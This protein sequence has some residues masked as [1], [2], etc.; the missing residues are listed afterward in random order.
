MGNALTDI[1]LLIESDS[2]LQHLNLPKGS[3]QLINNQQLDELRSLLNF[4]G[5]VMAAGGSA[6]N[7]I[8]GIARLGGKAGYFGCVGDDAIGQF[9]QNDLIDTGVTPHLTHSVNPSGTCTVLVSAD[10]E[11]TMCT[12]LGAAGE[13][14]LDAVVPELF[15]GYHYFHIEGYLAQNNA[16]ITKAIQL[17]KE[18]GLTVSIDL[19]SYNVVES[20][21]TF[22]REII[23][24]YVDIIFANEEEAIAFTGMPPGDAL[25]HMDHYCD[26]AIVKI[27]KDGSMIRKNKKTYFVEPF[28]V[29]CKDTTGAG[30]LYAAGFLF[31]LA[32]DFPLDKCGKIASYVSSKVVEVIGAKMED[33]QWNEI[34][35]KLLTF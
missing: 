33:S 26:M 24:Q 32:S 6:S 3:M 8:T 19:A 31:G 27:G 2:V 13:F 12:F 30:D 4:S 20:N 15:N 17:A 16:L 1:L 7:T 29:H 21:L 9:F 14:H 34:N 23:T 18:A 5:A 28:K 10:G 35:T 11:R 22:L 25:I